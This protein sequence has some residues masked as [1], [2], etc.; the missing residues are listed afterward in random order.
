MT[1]KKIL[2]LMAAVAMIATTGT[3]QAEKKYDKGATDTEIK[4]GNTAPYT[5]PASLYSKFSNC[6]AAF[7]KM[8]NDNGGVNGR[9]LN[10][11]SLDDGFNP[12][13]TVGQTRKLVEEEGV[14][15]MS[16]A[17][18]TGPQLSVAK[19]LNDNKI[20]S[21]FA[22]TGAPVLNNPAKYP[23]TFLGIGDYINEM[24]LY[25]DHIVATMP[26]AKI[27]VL[28]A[29]DDFGVSYLTPLRARL[30]FHKK[31]SMLVKVE[32]YDNA[33]PSVTPQVLALKASG[34]NVLI[35]I[36]LPRAAIQS[37]QELKSLDWSPAHYLVSVSAS[38]ELVFAA[39][40]LE[41]SKGIIAVTPVQDPADP[42]Y[43]GADMTAYKGFMSKYMSGE[44]PNDPLFVA[45][46]VIASNVVGILKAAGDNLTHENL[47]K[48]ASSWKSNG[49]LLATGTSIST[50]ASDHNMFKIR[51]LVQFDGALYQPLAVG[52]AK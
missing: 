17:I 47:A 38:R 49:P 52:K 29:N 24:N 1:T 37:I 36:S 31:E 40:G 32:K 2:I 22:S 20:P 11:I 6:L 48:I 19:Y 3:A 41:K 27:G 18:G 13:F 15:F 30:A 23:Y 45:A 33:A 42:R 5:G 25:V 10:Y 43:A 46:Y 12:A 26:N 44:N 8:T 50:S 9:K 14:L 28:A 39:A 4:I 16:G 21:I 7:Y 35:N 34:A 51:N